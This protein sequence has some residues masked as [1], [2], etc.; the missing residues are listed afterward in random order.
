M[1]EKGGELE[2]PKEPGIEDSS[3]SVRMFI[4]GNTEHFVA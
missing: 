1:S 4:I 3:H 2:K